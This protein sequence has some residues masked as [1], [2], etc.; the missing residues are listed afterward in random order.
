MTGVERQLAELRRLTTKMA[1]VRDRRI[2][3]MLALRAQDVSYRQIGEAAG[4]TPEAV[5]QMV[6]NHSK[7]PS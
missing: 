7:V 4:V 3:L 5:I 6:R 2:E 1:E